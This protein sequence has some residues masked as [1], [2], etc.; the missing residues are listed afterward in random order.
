MQIAY[1]T[2]EVNTQTRKIEQLLNEWS[3]NKWKLSC[4]LRQ[5]TTTLKD[6]MLEKVKLSEDYQIIK[7]NFPDANISD[8]ILKTKN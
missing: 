7:N 8:I 6:T 4:E 1:T 3:D 5:T 2:S